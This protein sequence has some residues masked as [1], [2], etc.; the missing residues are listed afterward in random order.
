MVLIC[1]DDDDDDDDLLDH[2]GLTAA[3]TPF[4]SLQ[5]SSQAIQLW[6]Y[7]IHDG[8]DGDGDGGDGDGDGDGVDHQSFSAAL[9][10]REHWC[11]TSSLQSPSAARSCCN[12][13]GGDSHGG[14]MTTNKIK[15]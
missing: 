8:N 4:F 11:H 5:A 1:R 12:D 9:W 15:M 6:Q 2:H 3:W 7:V 14:D 10:N 13:H